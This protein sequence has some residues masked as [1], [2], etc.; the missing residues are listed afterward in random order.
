MAYSPLLD[1][2]AAFTNSLVGNLQAIST[3]AQ[4]IPVTLELWSTKIFTTM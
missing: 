2:N 4:Y 3:T 1:P